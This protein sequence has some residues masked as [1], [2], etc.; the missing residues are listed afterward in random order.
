[1]S[2]LNLDTDR[3]ILRNYRHE[4]WERVHI[5]ASVSEF[6][7]FELWG[8][9][10]VEDTKKF[11]SD[12]VTQTEQDDRYKFDFA[13]C[14]KADGLL[15]GGCGIRRESQSSC[16]ANLGWAISPAFQSR[17]LA[18]EAAH[19]LIRFG[20][21]ELGLVVI[22]ATCDIRNMPSARVMEK[23]RMN[24]VGY[25]KGDKVQKGHLRDTYRYELTRANSR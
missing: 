24:R 21:D 9:N 7:Q 15:V 25:I 6:S 1:M 20:F 18:T 12:M 14:L 17:G 4:D 3:L 5:Y 11:V 16:V 13:V 10:T 22:Y 2:E 23:L 8:P 19:R